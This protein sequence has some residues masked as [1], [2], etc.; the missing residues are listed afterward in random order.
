MRALQGQRSIS[1]LGFDAQDFG[2]GAAHGIAPDHRAV[3]DRN[4]VGRDRFDAKIEGASL[5]GFFHPCFDQAQIF[6]E[7]RVLQVD[8]QR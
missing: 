6:V 5:A 8:A 4:A 1:F 7:D 3:E 2:F